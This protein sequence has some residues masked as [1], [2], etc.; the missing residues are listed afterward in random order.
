MPFHFK[1]RNF[2]KSKI[3]PEYIKNT[4]LYI[5]KARLQEIFK[6]RIFKFLV[7][8]SVGAFVQLS[9]LQIWRLLFPFQ[10]A[11]FLAI[12][13]AVISNF[14]FNNFWTFSDRKLQSKQYFSKFLQFNLASGGSIIIQQ[15]IAFLGEM[16]LGLFDLFTLPIINF[17]IDTG[18]MYAVVGIL[19][20]MFWNFF[21]Y[22]K[23]IWKKQNKAH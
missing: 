2:G 1:D 8:G 12:E 16:Y 6:N 10:L 20:G 17:T 4:L 9:T 15:L 11:F 22:S 7:V 13:G 19:I 3:G 18:T 14:I 5:M 23:I 21:A